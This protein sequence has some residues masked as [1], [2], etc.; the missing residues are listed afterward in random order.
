MR[1]GAL[2]FCARAR[3]GVMASRNGSAIAVPM[4]R[5]NVRR[6]RAWRVMNISVPP[7]YRNALTAFLCDV[8]GI[9]GVFAAPRLERQAPDDL[10]D[11]RAQPVAVGR[12]R[13]MNRL[14]AA[15]VV[16]L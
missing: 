14:N 3:A 16:R 2:P 4:P 15:S 12:D 9:P 10:M 11:H 5:R 13:A 8:T 1:T 6:A 7:V